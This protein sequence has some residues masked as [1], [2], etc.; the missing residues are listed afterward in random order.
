[1][2]SLWDNFVLILKHLLS[3]FCFIQAFALFLFIE[4]FGVKQAKFHY[5]FTGSNFKFFKPF[6]LHCQYPQLSQ[7]TLVIHDFAI[8]YSLCFK[9]QHLWTLPFNSIVKVGNFSPFL[10]YNILDLNPE[11]KQHSQNGEFLNIL[12]KYNVM[13][14]S[15]RQQ[16]D[17]MTVTGRGEILSNM[18]DR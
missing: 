15:E 11:F 13:V 10:I 14:A 3:S 4:A 12:M 7:N 17:D 18:T 1:M 9:L 5:S 16:R 2:I 8:R 6:E